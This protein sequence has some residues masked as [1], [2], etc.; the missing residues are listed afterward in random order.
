LFLGLGDRPLHGPAPA[1]LT[2]WWSSASAAKRYFTDP[3]LVW[4]ADQSAIVKRSRRVAEPPDP[5]A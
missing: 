2:R 1:G 3:R 4:S 5:V